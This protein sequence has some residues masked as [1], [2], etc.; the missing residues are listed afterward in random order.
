MQKN[1][2]EKGSRKWGSNCGKEGQMKRKRVDKEGED[3]GR[4]RRTEDT[5]N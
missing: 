5:I 4:K 2:R 3:G 1:G